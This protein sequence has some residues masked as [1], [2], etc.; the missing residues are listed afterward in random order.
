MSDWEASSFSGSSMLPNFGPESLTN[1]SLKWGTIHYLQIF[2]DHI[3]V[4]MW[5]VERAKNK[6]WLQFQ[7]KANANQCL[8]VNIEAICKI[9]GKKEFQ[10]NF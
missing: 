2:R 6:D 7:V 4:F 10:W 9:W 5:L 8:H 3:G 1:L